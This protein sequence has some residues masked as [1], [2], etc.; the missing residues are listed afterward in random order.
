MDNGWSGIVVHG[1]IR[2]SAVI[3]Q[4]PIAVFA[5]GTNP[6]KTDKRGEGRAEVTLEINGVA[7]VPGGSGSWATPMA[8]WSP[9]VSSSAERFSRRVRHR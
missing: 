5:L 8:W 4:M 7:I 3:A 9:L 6:R 1:A 2:D